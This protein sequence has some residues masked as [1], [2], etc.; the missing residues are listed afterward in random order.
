M[1]KELIELFEAK[2]KEIEA[3]SPRVCQDYN[4]AIMLRGA[5]NLLKE[6]D[7]FRGAPAGTETVSSDAVTQTADV[8]TK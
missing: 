8:Q 6:A 4:A 7:S 3:R 1:N 5:V 2:A